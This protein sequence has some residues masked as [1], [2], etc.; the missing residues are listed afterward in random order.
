MARPVVGIVFPFPVFK[1]KEETKKRA[2]EED[3]SSLK[4]QLCFRNKQTFQH[5]NGEEEEEEALAGGWAAFQMSRKLTGE[6]L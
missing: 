4:I 2:K 3:E 1:K 5:W 6:D